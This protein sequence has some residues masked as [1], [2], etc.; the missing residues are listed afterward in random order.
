MIGVG[1]CGRCRG[2][3]TGR[4][5]RRGWYAGVW[6][7]FLSSGVCFG[8]FGLSWRVAA[9]VFRSCVCIDA[10]GRMILHVMFWSV[11]GRRCHVGWSS[12]DIGW[13]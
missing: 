7:R 5:G 9:T 2:T 3:G 4:L 12:G 11:F 8:M 1:G 10:V 13:R 6:Y